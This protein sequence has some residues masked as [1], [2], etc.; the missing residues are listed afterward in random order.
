MPVTPEMTKGLM[1]GG[2]DLRLR[3]EA[4]FGLIWLM[5]G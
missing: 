5:A 1:P 3:H 2:I 4:E